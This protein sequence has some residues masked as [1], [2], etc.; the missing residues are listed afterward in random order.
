MKTI[1]FISDP[2]HGW[3]LVLT[4]E[5]RALGIV[6]K[7]SRYSYLNGQTAALEEDCDLG[8]YCEAL[9]A[10]G[11]DYAFDEQYEENTAIRN[12]A[13]FDAGRVTP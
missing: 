2:G 11:I 12:W 5:L 10:A 8:V 7:I 13:S 1:K 6:D 9:R 3:A 4:S